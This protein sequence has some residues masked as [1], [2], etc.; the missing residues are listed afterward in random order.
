MR[1]GLLKMSYPTFVEGTAIDRSGAVAQVNRR[2][3]LARLVARSSQLPRAIVNRIWAHFLGYGFTQPVDDLGPHNPPSHPEL[4]DLLAREF[5]GSGYDV[6][7]LIGWIARS[8]AY[9]LSSRVPA[10]T[11]KEGKDNPLAGTP[12]L[13]SYFYVRQ[14]RPEELYESLLTFTGRREGGSYEEK[15]RAK[16]AWMQQFTGSYGTEENDEFTTFNGSITQTLVMFNGELTRDATRVDHSS[17]LRSVLVSNAMPNAKIGQLFLAALGR[18]P[19]GSELTM[20]N[21]LWMSR[22]QDAAAALQDIWWA[23]LNSNEFIMNH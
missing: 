9:S 6:K 8:E 5:A 13:Y 16:T 18:R 17:F 21:Q 7:R 23:V 12:P 20:A 19:T 14:M 10:A 2:D 22:Q 3:E 4:L 11:L 15:E 1:N